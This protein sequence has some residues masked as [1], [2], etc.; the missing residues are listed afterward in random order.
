MVSLTWNVEKLNSQKQGASWWLPEAGEVMSE[1]T[2]SPLDPRSKIRDLLHVYH[3]DSFTY[4]PDKC[5][6]E[7]L[8]VPRTCVRTHTH[9]AEVVCVLI[10]LT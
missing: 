10:S 9:I 1:G 3:N 8:S 7:I 2:E 5:Q 4:G 6:R